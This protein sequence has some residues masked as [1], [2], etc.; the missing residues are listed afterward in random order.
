MNAIIPPDLPPILRERS[1]MWA[2]IRR[3]VRQR[4]VTELAT[5]TGWRR[6]VLYWKI[7]REVSAE[8]KRK[9]PRRALYLRSRIRPR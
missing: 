9:F 5:T 3:E 6:L 4:Y 1:I 8:L 7:Q 2:K